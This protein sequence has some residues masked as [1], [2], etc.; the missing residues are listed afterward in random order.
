MRTPMTIGGHLDRAALVYG[1][2][3]GVHDEPGAPGGGLGAVTYQ[4]MRE[5]ARAQAANL[6]ERGIGRGERVARQSVPLGPLFIRSI[7]LCT[8]H[9]MAENIM[10][11]ATG[12]RSGAAP[13]CDAAPPAPRR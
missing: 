6:D 8:N 3:I 11:G 4:R 7:A 1:D 10:D 5:L 13:P 2:R 12:P 9:A